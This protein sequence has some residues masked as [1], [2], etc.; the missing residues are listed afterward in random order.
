[1]I[2]SPL[3]DI[4]YIYSDKEFTRHVN[5]LAVEQGLLRVSD[6]MSDNIRIKQ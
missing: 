4:S 5:R 2:F 1:M 3:N 6:K